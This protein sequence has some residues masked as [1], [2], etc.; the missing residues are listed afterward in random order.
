MQINWQAYLYK[1][2]QEQ[3]IHL[4]DSFNAIGL[5]LVNFICK[6]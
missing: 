1:K 4:K 3:Q 6:L 2:K 5:L